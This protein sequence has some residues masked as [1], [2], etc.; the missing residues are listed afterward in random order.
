MKPRLYLSSEGL[1]EPSA[2]WPCILWLAGQTGQPMALTQAARVLIGQ[3]VELLLPMELCSWVRTDPWPSRRHPGAQAI[4]FAVEDQLSEPLEALH[5]GIGARDAQGCYPVMV[6]NRERFAAV[7]ALMTQ[8]GVAVCA[9]FVDADVLPGDQPVAALWGGRWLL[10]GGLPARLVL[11]DE[12]LAQLEPALPAD[13]QRLDASHIDQLLCA[14]PAHAID[15][16]SGEFALRR[17]MMPWRSAGISLLTLALL[18]WA[19]GEVRLAFLQG[20]TRDLTARNEQRFKAL[21][22]DQPRVADLAAQLKAL[23]MQHTEPQHTHI[24]RLVSLMDRVVGASSVEVQRI[25]YRQGEGWKVQLT[26]NS[27]AELEQL[28]ERGRQQGMPIRLE[29]ASQQHKRVQATLAME[30]GA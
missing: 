23:Q 1:A 18:S 7:L 8:S 22:P 3:A 9:V 16:L 27:F 26:A 28:R 10:G 21:Y 12:G 11:C 25:D 2:Q 14:R 4:A 13:L 20:E 29:S 19:G 30:K 6:V 15:L 24:A 17:T 5:L